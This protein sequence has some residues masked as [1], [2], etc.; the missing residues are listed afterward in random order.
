MNAADDESLA[1]FETK[2]DEVTKILKMMNSTEKGDQLAGIHKADE[3]AKPKLKYNLQNSIINIKQTC[4][5][6]LGLDKEY[7]D[8]L[9]MDE[10]IVRVKDDRTVINH[11]AFEDDPTVYKWSKCYLRKTN[12]CAWFWGICQ[13]QATM[14]KLA[15]M[16]EVERDA[17]RRTKERKQ[18]EEVAQNLRK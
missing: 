16:S 4:V 6:F 1:S 2:I 8:K 11:A 18:R 7:Q 15:F 9:D 14:D 12:L 10:F 3:W 5:R 17:K 13:E